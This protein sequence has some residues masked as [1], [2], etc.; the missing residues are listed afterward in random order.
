MANRYRTPTHFSTRWDASK[1]VGDPNTVAAFDEEGLPIYIDENEL[2]GG[3]GTGGG[4]PDGTIV[5]TEDTILDVETHGSKLLIIN[6]EEPITI[7]LP[8]FTTANSFL[9]IK[10]RSSSD[11]P[12]VVVPYEGATL[13][14]S[15]EGITIETQFVSLH[16]FYSST[17]TFYIL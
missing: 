13:D 4:G 1:Q 11:Y 7:T 10:K 2:G 12:I 17:D 8:E 16:I 14:D 15:T 5:I 3:G 9:Y 6:N